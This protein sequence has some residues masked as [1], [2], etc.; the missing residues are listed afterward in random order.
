MED[1]LGAWGWG[2]VVEEL[3]STE[4]LSGLWFSSSIIGCFS[5]CFIHCNISPRVLAA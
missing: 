5:M 1:C 2:L 3:G 4:E